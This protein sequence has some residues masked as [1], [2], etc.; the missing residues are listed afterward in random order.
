[1]RIAK[2]NPVTGTQDSSTCFH[3]PRRQGGRRSTPTTFKVATSSIDAGDGAS[4]RVGPAAGRP[5]PVGRQRRARREGA[6]A[7]R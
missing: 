2:V 1:L 4:L 6:A 7:S 3:A 5:L